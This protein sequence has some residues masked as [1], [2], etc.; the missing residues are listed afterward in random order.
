MEPTTCPNC[1]APMAPR[2][3][4]GLYG[5]PVLI[6]ACRACQGFW[7]DDTESLQLSPRGTLALFR[8][9]AERHA[10]ERQPLGTRLQCPRCD[11]KLSL[12][13]DQQRTTRFQ[14]FRCVR[15]HGRFITFFQFL[16]ARNFVRSLTPREVAE[17]RAK[18]T[19]VHCSNCGGGIGLDTD[20]ACPYCRVPVSMLDPHQVQAALQE[21]RDADA[22]RQQI[23]PALPLTLMMEQLRAERVFA[24]AAGGGGASRGRILGGPQGLVEAGLSL[25]FR[26]MS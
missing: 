1:R 16:R 5:R 10:R 14:Y 13:L 23:D 18:V 24:E 22:R 15:G 12:T 6:D 4:E 3:I 7:F 9:V 19:Q 21:L 20:V 8:L 17:L 26:W 11:L 25:V 2:E